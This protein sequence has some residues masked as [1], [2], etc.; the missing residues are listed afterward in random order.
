MSIQNPLKPLLALIQHH[1]QR[2]FNYGAYIRCYSWVMGE[3]D[4]PERKEKELEVMTNIL[5]LNKIK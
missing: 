1:T 5:I 4:T 3:V 2:E